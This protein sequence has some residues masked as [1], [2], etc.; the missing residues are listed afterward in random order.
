MQSKVIVDVTGGTI[1]SDYVDGV[2]ITPVE[3]GKRFLSLR[4]TIEIAGYKVPWHKIS[5]V[6]SNFIHDKERNE[7]IGPT[8][9][10]Q[11]NE[12]YDVIIY[13]GS[14]TLSLTTNILSY[15]LYALN[16]KIALT[17]ALYDKSFPK[18]DIEV[19]KR[20]SLTFAMKG[21]NYSGVYIVF[22]G[23]ALCPFLWGR[24]RLD[25]H[26]PVSEL[27]R[28]SDIKGVFRNLEV[29]LH[30][31]NIT[32]AELLRFPFDP[33]AKISGDEIITS[34]LDRP[35]YDE[36]TYL[37]VEDKFHYC[38]GKGGE[39]RSLDFRGSPPT[40]GKLAEI[41]DITREYGR[42]RK[43]AID[44]PERKHDAI[45]E[46]ETLLKKIDVDPKIFTVYWKDTKTEF[47]PRTMVKEVLV[48]NPHSDPVGYIKSIEDG[49]YTG[50]VILGEGFGHI[51]V[52]EWKSLIKKAR[53]YLVPVSM[54]TKGGLITSDRYAV[55]V[56]IYV[57]GVNHSGTLNQDEGQVRTAVIVGHKDKR[58]FINEDAAET[59]NVP[60][61][62]IKNKAY[63]SGMLFRNAKE[64]N[65]WENNHHYSTNY[66]ILD[67]S[68][69]KWEEKILWS[70]L[71]IAYISG[72]LPRFHLG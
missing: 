55:A 37:E 6:D 7:V 64:R 42:L 51:D 19:N 60:P 67:A 27:L 47:D 43:M 5:N 68:S 2:G 3:N 17:L 21:D 18:S 59:F 41:N 61:L 46:V 9:A 40:T 34:H 38:E 25:L 8:V 53:D 63:V 22:G 49:T 70:A 48:A 52:N 12:G 1:G 28:L 4:P 56:P 24:H 65:E 44:S 69:M 30:Q 15:S 23:N 71:D 31:P 26:N 39:V 66:D 50:I 14:D 13:H 62:E 20:D 45:A 16:K 35:R 58:D 11:V 10:K 54:V 57:E 29:D 36:T 72:R 33:I 32:L